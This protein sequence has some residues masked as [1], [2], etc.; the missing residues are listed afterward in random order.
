MA[1]ITCGANS[2]FAFGAGLRTIAAATLLLAAI[3]VPASAQ[4]GE[5][6]VVP[7][8]EYFMAF[9]IF[10]D[11]DFR[12]ALK[13]FNSI[14]K[15]GV[16]ST[17]GR[18]VDSIC[19]HT[20]M[21]ECYYQMG[22]LGQA[23]DHY[24]AALELF[25][26]NRNWT[27]RVQF[28]DIINPSS[29]TVRTRITWG[30]SARRSRLGVF[31][32]QMSTLQG[33]S[34]A[35]N[36][37]AIR[38][39]GVVMSPVYYPL[40]VQEIMRCICL[41]MY[42]R[43]VLMGPA[44]RYD[45]ITNALVESLARRPAPVNHWSQ[46][47]ISVQLGLAYAGAG[48]TAEAVTELRKGLLVAGTYDHPLTD[49]ALLELG[50]LHFEQGHL[51]E[52]GNFFLEATFAAAQF[53][54]ASMIEEG[55]RGGLVA[56]FVSGKN[57]IYPPLTR[58]IPYARSQ[59][60]RHLQALLLVMA[61]ESYAAT[62]Q[63]PQAATMLEEA[64]RSMGRFD[65][66]DGATGAYHKYQLALIAFQKGD[67]KNG[68]AALK[69]AMAYQQK[70]S[71]LLFHIAIV[72][73]LYTT[74]RLPST[75]VAKLL[76]DAVLREPTPADWNVHP[77]ETLSV[78]LTPHVLP[79]EHWFEVALAQKQ[80]EAALEI[81][82]R[83]RR[84]RFFSTLPMGGRLLALRW[85][86]E[87]PEDAL[88]ETARLQRRDLLVKYPRY[89][90]LSRAAAELREQMARQPLVPDDDGQLRQQKEA[91]GQ[92]ADLTAGREL[93]LREIALRRDPSEF[94]F[95]PLKTT[96]EIRES[97]DEKQIA[98][99]FFAT[100]RFVYAFIFTR[101]KYAHWQIESPAKIQ[102]QVVTM[103]KEMGHFGKD[104]EF[105]ADDLAKGTWKK[106]AGEVLSLLTNQAKP[107]FWDS[108]DELIVVPDNVLWYV[109]FESLQVPGSDGGTVSLVSKLRIRYAPTASLMIPDGRRMRAEAK[110]AVVLGKLSPRDAET[111]AAEAFEELSLVDPGSVAITGDLPVP[112][113]FVTT[114]WDRL[115]VLDDVDDA[116]RMPYEW[117]P[118]RLDRGK[119]G[120]S[121]GSWIE[122]PF[123]GPEQVIFPGFHTA[124]EDGLSRGSGYEVF[125]T[126][127]GLMAA[128]ART[129]LI[130]RW[131]VGGQ[132]D[133]DLVREFLQELPHVPASHA[134]HRSLMLTRATPLDPTRE[135]RL[136]LD[137]SKEP[138]NAAHPLFWAGYLLADTGSDPK[139]EPAAP[140]PD[141]AAGVA[142]P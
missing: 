41:S 28:P 91:F 60:F 65:M 103:L 58:A 90:E 68:M 80:H 9:S 61:A 30:A 52:A 54:H 32:D 138:P 109:P 16:R 7:R 123:K 73:R 111:T 136:R 105:T 84:H 15:G 3:A 8:D 102:K 20:M 88:T 129:V 29:S 83:V 5:S 85:V 130:S 82:D 107:D 113:N 95:P 89:A 119:L 125:L 76:F 14:A 127:C 64:R 108:Y 97:L 70:G 1:A 12:D 104:R 62:G 36:A 122:L 69:L 34:N 22:E 46:A 44:C 135:P 99:A 10:H 72:D 53:G 49:I 126:V 101:D 2:S 37:N 96:Q 48:K 47:W 27:L 35:A 75:R 133:F 112:S 141:A 18:W 67:L 116:A 25:L 78:V 50:K 31:P 40:R 74:S 132:T 118:A 98:L 87:A 59:R 81:A 114:L 42:R 17:E 120:S 38:R 131:R 115:V 121:L 63:T 66:A 124:A 39:G 43:R 11:G 6:R 110:T 92:L 140:P 77:M 19:Y 137:P 71:H 57:G 55:F 134:W 139:P 56:H 51:D 128:G 94:L 106:P 86:L 23:L 117:A 45:T 33:Q 21:G 4:R 100:S 93:I 26:A 142:K 24:N 13:A 79:M